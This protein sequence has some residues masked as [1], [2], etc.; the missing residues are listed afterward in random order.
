MTPTKFTSPIINRPYD[1]PEWHWQRHSDGRIA[2]SP[3]QSGR[4]PA[5]GRL[6]NV[7]G[8]DLPSRNPLQAM[9]D[10]TDLLPQLAMVNDIRREVSAWQSQGYAGATRVTRELIG[11]WTNPDKGGLYFAQKE[12]VLTAIWLGEI[13]PQ[14]TAGQAILKELD[15]IN[16]VINDGIPRIC[17]QMAT[18]T[19]KTAVM[20]AIILWQTCNHR[21][22]PG[23]ARFTN[24]FLAITPGITV[25]ERLAAGLQYMKHGQP[26]QTTEYLNPH[27][28]LVPPQY[29]SALRHIRLKVVNYHKFIPQDPDGQMPARAKTL[30]RKASNVETEQQVIDRVLGQAAGPMVVFNDEAHHCHQGAPDGTGS[31]DAGRFVWFSA[32]Q[33]LHR[34]GL[35]HGPVRDLS[36]TPSFIDAPNAP[37]FPWIVSQYGL[38]EAEEAGIVKIM[39]L[40]NDGN[41]PDEWDDELARSIYVNTRDGKNL[42]REDDDSDNKDLKIAL[43]MM[44]ENWQAVWQNAN[45]RQRSVP[46]VLAVIVNTIR[47][48]NRVFDYIAGWESG[49]TLYPGRLGNELSNIDVNAAGYHAHPRTILV[50]SR[51]EDPNASEKGEEQQYLKRQAEIYRRLYPSAVTADNVP[52]ALASDKD[53]LRTALNTVGKAGQP[54]ERVRCVVSVG[55]LTEGWDARTVTHVVGFRRF[56]TQLICEQVSGRALRR[57]AYDTNEDGYLYPEYADILGVPFENL[58]RGRAGPPGVSPPTPPHYDVHIVDARADLKIR[59]PNVVDYRR[60]QGRNPLSLAPPADWSTVPAYEAPDHDH[61]ERIRTTPGAPAGEQNPLYEQAATRQ[62]FQYLAAKRAVDTLTEMDR[63]DATL[64]RGRLFQQALA[65]IQEAQRQGTLHG[66][67]RADRWPNRHTEEPRRAAQWLLEHAAVTVDGATA[68][69]TTAEPICAVAGEPLWLDSRRL[70]P[71]QSNRAYKHE[72]RKSEVNVAVCDSDWEAA[73]AEILDLHPNIKRWIRNERLGWTIPYRYDGMPRNYEPDFIAAATLAD[74]RTLHIV[75]EVKGLARETDADKQRWTTQYWLPAVNAHPDFSKSGPWAYLYI[76]REP[77]ESYVIA[78]LSDA[79][80]QFGAA[81]QEAEREWNTRFARPESEELLARLAKDA[82]SERQAGLTR[83][84][85]PDEL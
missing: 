61:A 26:D 2:D 53:V 81:E 57:V 51:L 50:H 33:M 13:A 78:A 64:S 83:P 41:R 34:H 27:L 63:E 70:L 8:L 55:M 58:G 44:Y 7:S 69:G 11:H 21:E 35:R 45:W 73:V 43:Q 82:L 85:N 52:F 32:L 59:W 67:E 28:H 1:Q 75:I 24:R 66:P 60:P 29:E 39:R 76:D 71:Y 79:I 80:L 77:T 17:H 25:Q 62:E 38:Q 84:L 68:D 10:L 16:G 19:G 6:P 48:A 36:A 5:T 23:D 31:K 42:T 56:G 74:G 47:N 22:Y 46:P 9:G 37:L 14:T 54:G 40:P 65:I 20:A 12:A 3:Q 4:Y 72:T 49:D 30:A 15:E 18:G